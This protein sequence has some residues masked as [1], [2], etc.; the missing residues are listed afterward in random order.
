VE[1]LLRRL[2]WVGLILGCDGSSQLNTSI[3]Y[4]EFTD[5]WASV[6]SYRSADESEFELDGSSDTGAGIDEMLHMTVSDGGDG[7]LL[8][9]S[10]G[11]SLA[12]STELA[13]LQLSTD[14][15]LSIR[16]VDGV[17]QDPDIVVLERNFSDGGVVT[18]GDWTSTTRMLEQQS[19]WYGSFD[20]V[21]D[22]N[23]EGPSDAVP[24]MIRIAQDVGPV[25]FIWGEYTG[26]LA[27]YDP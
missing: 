22:V 27:W 23:L 7:R 4:S 8:V 25:Q 19:T 15:G 3:S 12:E 16:S 5:N 2:A 13:Q 1:F 24:G 10:L 14:G 26:D 17:E 20:F 21:V 9:L 11:D 18:S 6:L